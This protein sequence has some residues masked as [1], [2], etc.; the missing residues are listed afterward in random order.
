M[1]AYRTDRRSKGDSDG[2]GRT[3]SNIPHTIFHQHTTTRHANTETYL[4]TLRNCNANTHHHPNSATYYPRD[5]FI[6]NK[7]K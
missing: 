7:P 3:Q 1:Y 5:R 2:Y 6:Q 4:Y